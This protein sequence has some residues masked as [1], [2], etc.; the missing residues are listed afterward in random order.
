MHF[1]KVATLTG[2]LGVL[3]NNANKL[4]LTMAEYGPFDTGFNDFVAAPEHP[5][6]SSADASLI[7][8]SRLRRAF[9]DYRL[10]AGLTQTEISNRLD[11]SVS[12]VH[13][14][15][16]GPTGISTADALVLLSMYGVA[17]AEERGEVIR[18]VR[19]VR[20]QAKDNTYKNLFPKA[21][22]QYLACEATANSIA[23]FQPD[24][25]P[26]IMQ[27]NAYAAAVDHGRNID[28]AQASAIHALRKQ[29][30][31]YLLGKYGPALTVIMDESILHRAVG[32][33]QLPPD[34]IY[35]PLTTVIDRLKRLNTGARPEPRTEWSDELNPHISIQ[36][37]PFE[38]DIYPL[39][40]HPYTILEFPDA[41]DPP[42]LYVHD[43]V[44]PVFTYD[45]AESVQAHADTFQNL[46]ECMPKPNATNELLDFIK[47]TYT[48]RLQSGFMSRLRGDGL[49]NSA[50]NR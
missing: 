34:R 11:W 45:S 37:V 42:A 33:E 47:Q 8:E 18:K 9:I 3:Y 26:D 5:L 20:Q 1:D 17:G 48:R 22:A 44:K 14:I 12:K 49:E 50:S 40:M 6:A 16:N 32:G 27:T 31:A 4:R 30:A 13:R 23:I 39:P 2:I 46:A 15:E 19:A 24:V 36:I 38:A 28:P 10:A 25:V 41:Q 7:A 43:T 35:E 29:R 21:F